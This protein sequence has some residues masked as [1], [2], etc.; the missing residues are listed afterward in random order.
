MDLFE[1]LRPDFV[2]EN[3][4]GIL[5]QLIH[6]GF[7][8]VNVLKSKK[9]TQRGEH[10]HK[11]SREAFYVANGSVMLT[12]KKDGQTQEVFFSE[13]EFFLIPTYVWHS[14]DFPEDCTLVA[15][16]DIPVEQPDGSKDIIEEDI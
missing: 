12:L 6:A 9:G 15:L 13:G 3:E 10:Y 8:Q 11:K 1:S 7:S 4:K 2:F 5:V 14:M 16:Y